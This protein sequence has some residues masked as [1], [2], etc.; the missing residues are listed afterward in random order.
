MDL[1][2]ERRE[3]RRQ[4]DWNIGGWSKVDETYQDNERRGDEDKG[5]DDAKHKDRNYKVKQE[6]TKPHL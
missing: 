6:M 2:I 5:G 4:E 3:T 1:L